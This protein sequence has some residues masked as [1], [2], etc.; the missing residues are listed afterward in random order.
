MKQLVTASL[1]AALAIVVA[2][3][4]GAADAVSKDTPARI[5]AI[6]IQTLTLSDEQFL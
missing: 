2:H 4:A 3:P 6:P 5:E 1:L